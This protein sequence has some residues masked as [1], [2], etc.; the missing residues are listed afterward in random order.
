[1]MLQGFSD[2]RELVEYKRMTDPHKNMA[3]KFLWKL[4]PTSQFIWQDKSPLITVKMVHLSIAHGMSPVSSIGFAFF[5]QLLVTL[6]YVREGC[7]YAKIAK[8]MLNSFGSKEVAGEVIAVGSQVLSFVEPLQTIVEFHAEGY[9]IAMAAGSLS[10][11]MGNTLFYCADSFWAGVKL[12]DC[13]DRYTH[14]LGFF[15]LRGNL[16]FHAAMTRVEKNIRLLMGADEGG[17]KPS[18]TDDV[19]Q[20]LQTNPV[21]SFAVFFQ[22]MYIHYIFCESVKMKKSAELFFG[23]S[24]PTIWT[25]Y[26][27]SVRNNLLICMLCLLSAIS[28]KFVRLSFL[29]K[30]INNLISLHPSSNSFSLQTVHVFFGGLVAFRL[31][32]E[33]KD[34]I[35]AERGQSAKIATKKWA[36]FSQHNFQHRVYLLEAE[37]AFCNND[38]ESAQLLYE[39]AISAARRHR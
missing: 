37:E 39:S 13:K 20:D 11:A 6:G 19:E 33:T 28:V 16:A 4:A 5:G 30:P 31:Y 3:M 7:R 32:R 18:I 12:A 29:T 10:G 26:H 34:P 25:I 2:E 23:V 15:Q 17:D 35:W 38:N 8:M 27:Y 14:A 36:E 21:G 24:N 1:M 22:K 9:T